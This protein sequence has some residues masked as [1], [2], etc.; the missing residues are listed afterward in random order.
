MFLHWLKVTSSLLAF[1]QSDVERQEVSAL[2]HRAA[3][4]EAE[5]GAPRLRGQSPQTHPQNRLQV[6]MRPHTLAATLA[7]LAVLS[8]NICQCLFD[9]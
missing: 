7:L 1:Q 3:P 4:Q 8:T 6:R 5:D 9:W 2:H